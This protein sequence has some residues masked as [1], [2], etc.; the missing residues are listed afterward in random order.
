MCSK[1]RLFVELFKR[2]PASSAWISVT[3]R[4]KVCADLWYRLCVLLSCTWRKSPTSRKTDRIQAKSS[5]CWRSICFQ[6]DAVGSC[7]CIFG[8]C[9]HT[10]IMHELYRLDRKRPTWTYFRRFHIGTRFLRAVPIDSSIF[11]KLNWRMEKMLFL[12]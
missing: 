9:K 11:Q 10:D 6:L 4:A 8:G 1:R 7:V 2:C 3:T 12:L 5:T